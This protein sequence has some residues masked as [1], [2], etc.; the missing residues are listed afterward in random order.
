M[1]SLCWRSFKEFS[2]SKIVHDQLGFVRDYDF[3]CFAFAVEPKENF[4]FHFS[5]AHLFD[6]VISSTWHFRLFEI[7]VVAGSTDLEKLKI[8]I[9]SPRNGFFLLFVNYE[10][11]ES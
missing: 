4:L 5:A 11:R 3:S 7:R 1:T 8:F 6:F 9:L 10:F 2:T